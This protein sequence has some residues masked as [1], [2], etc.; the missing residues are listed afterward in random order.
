MEGGVAVDEGGEVA[1]ET[2]EVAI[3]GVT[4]GT[5]VASAIGEVVT[6][7]RPAGGGV[8][9]LAPD[10]HVLRGCAAV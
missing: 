7:V 3:G 1:V 10:P 9:L 5:V 8:V 4:V 6:V 2:V